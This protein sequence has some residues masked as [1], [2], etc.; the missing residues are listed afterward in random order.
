MGN[1][2][3][4][5]CEGEIMKDRPNGLDADA[6]AGANK[7]L[8][9]R[10]FNEG[11]SVAYDEDG[12]TLFLTIGEGREAITEQV[13]DGIYFRIEPHTQKFVG[14]VIMRF[15]SDILANNKLVRKLFQESFEQLRRHGDL[16]QWD[17]L[18]AQKIK[19]L[20]ELVPTR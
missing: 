19:P 20:F 12:D 8:A 1:W 5:R 7:D 10:L 4:L 3:S 11:I 13:V 9:E 15:V 18:D 17:G 6:V 14:C 2:Y 16:A